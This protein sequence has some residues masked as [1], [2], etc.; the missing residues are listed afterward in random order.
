M[1]PQYLTIRPGIHDI[2]VTAVI[3]AKTI[4]GKGFPLSVNVTVADIGDYPETF[5]VTAYANMTAVN[6]PSNVSLTSGDSTAV[7]FT[8][9]T[10]TFDMGNYSISAVADPVPVEINTTN[11][12]C[13]DGFITITIPGDINGDFRV[14]LADLVILAQ[15]FGSR[16]DEAKWNS[17]V[18]IDANG[19]VSL[20]DLVTL[21]VYYGQ[22]YG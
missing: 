12:N 16:P 17:N 1:P 18:D 9:N 21:A 4:I 20:A 14:S 7:M 15:A 3:P 8:L 13:T 2:A 11:N 10:S 22:H 19:V 6:P 5:D